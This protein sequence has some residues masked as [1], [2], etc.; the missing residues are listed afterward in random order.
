M[1]VHALPQHESLRL[2]FATGRV[3]RDRATRRRSCSRRRTTRASGSP[4][5]QTASNLG[6]V[7]PPVERPYR[8]LGDPRAGRR[9]AGRGPGRPADD[10]DLRAPGGA[11]QR[12]EVT[13]A[14]RAAGGDGP[15]PYRLGEA[16]PGRSPP[17]RR[18]TVQTTVCVSAQGHADLT[19]EHRSLG[20][21]A[22]PPLGPEPGPS[23]DVGLALSGV[24]L[25]PTGKPCS[26]RIRARARYHEGSRRLQDRFDT[27]RLA[28]RIDERIVHDDDRRR[29]PRVHRG[30][31]HVLHRDRGR[32][33]AGRSAR[34]RAASR[35]SCASSTSGRSPSRSTTATACT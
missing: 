32:R 25:A 6:L 29:R 7:A 31:R 34:T 35:A 30:A 22:G 11:T 19:L 8:A 24:Q 5:T 26:R 17:G 15:D 12:V 3:R 9:T 2:D 33:R 10:P 4:A 13:S 20:D 28:D 16:R 1:D 21:V 14:R 18:A 27:R 23:R